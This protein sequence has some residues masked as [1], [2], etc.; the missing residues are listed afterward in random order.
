ML[1]ITSQVTEISNAET[2][3]VNVL[4]WEAEN[5]EIAEPMSIDQELEAG[6]EMFISTSA[7]GMGTATFHL[8]FPQGMTYRVWC[9][10]KTIGGSGLFALSID[11][12]GEA[13]ATVPDDGSGAWRWVSLTVGAVP[14]DFLANDGLHRII[15]RGVT[16][17]T[18]LDK[19]CISNDPEWQPVSFRSAPSLSAARASGGVLLEWTDPWSNA[20]AYVIE[21]STDGYNF[22][23]LDTV[24]STER[25]YRV[26]GQAQKAYYRIYAFNELDRGASSAVVN[27]S[28]ERDGT[29]NA[30][31]NVAAQLSE[32]GQIMVMWTDTSSDETGFVL[33]RSTD[34]HNFAIVQRVAADSTSVMDTPPGPGRYYYRV[35]AVSDDAKSEPTDSLAV[36]F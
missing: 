28:S 22:Q 10:V 5:A 27:L 31:E 21:S 15:L 17:D 14:L 36:R 23:T 9:R 3:A 13:L 19:I 4:A 26:S 18:R 2:P 35:R 7:A 1:T 25:S 8:D 33:E 30:P 20:A 34:R 6:G 32:E 29:P 11:G 24:D 16:L 12:S